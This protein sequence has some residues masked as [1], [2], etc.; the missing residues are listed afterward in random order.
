MLGRFDASACL[1]VPKLVHQERSTPNGTKFADSNQHNLF[2][3]NWKKVDRH[4]VRHYEKWVVEHWAAQF[5]QALV[6]Q[7]PSTLPPKYDKI[8]QAMVYAVSHDYMGEI[9]HLTQLY[10]TER[11]RVRRFDT[12]IR[13]MCLKVS[14]EAIGCAFKLLSDCTWD[15]SSHKWLRDHPDID[16]RLLACLLT[17]KFW[18]EN[19]G[20]GLVWGKSGLDELDRWSG[21]IMVKGAIGA[22]S[23]HVRTAIKYRR[24]LDEIKTWEMDQEKFRDF[25]ILTDG[26]FAVSH[27]PLTGD[28][29]VGDPLG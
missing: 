23:D 14:S 1:Y 9:Q 17:Y 3:L 28:Q 16:R 5:P 29:G 19:T 12:C 24:C 26:K 4:K 21:L 8:V 25:T 22:D 15:E 27:E 18:R 2:T 10:L 11:A 20:S 7:N 6:G 13:D